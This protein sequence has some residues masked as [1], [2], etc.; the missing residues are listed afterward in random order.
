MS[1]PI[2]ILSVL[3]SV[4]SVQGAGKA[5]TFAVVG[6]TGASAQQIFLG[7]SSFISNQ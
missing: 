4:L 2:T 3:A 7:V 1:I 5:N 6:N